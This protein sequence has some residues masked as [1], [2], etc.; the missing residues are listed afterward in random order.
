MAVTACTTT[1]HDVIVVG[2]GFAGIGVWSSA[3]SSWYL[4]EN[5]KNRTL[6]P[7]FSFKFR[8]ATGEFR[9]DDYGFAELAGATPWREFAGA[10]SV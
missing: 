2:T 7:G 6:W 8:Q 9:A 1:H 4:G 5:G 10:N 3:C